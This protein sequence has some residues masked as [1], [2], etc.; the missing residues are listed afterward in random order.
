MTEPSADRRRLTIVIPAAMKQRLQLVAVQHGITAT[1][2]VEA[3]V[4]AGF[5]SEHVGAII[6]RAQRINDEHRL[7]TRGPARPRDP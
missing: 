3:M 1:S 4:E 5:A 7:Y 2:L 6:S